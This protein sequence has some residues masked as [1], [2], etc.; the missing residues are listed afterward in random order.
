LRGGAN[1]ARIRLQ[2]QAGWEVNQPEQLKAVLAKYE[3]IQSGTNA[4]LADLIVLGG[5]VGIEM[6][7]KKAGA[8]INVPFAPGRADASQEQTDVQSFKV[9]EPLYDGFRNYLQ[10]DFSTAAESLLV[11]KAQLLGLTAPEMTVLLGGLRM[12]GNN[13]GGSSHGVFTASPETLSND[14]FVNLLDMDTEW[15]PT[16]DKNVFNGV[17]RKS[18]TKKWTAT[19]ADLIFG[20]NSQL[21][22]ISEVYASDDAKGKFMSDFVA[23]WNKVM[24][25]DRFDLKR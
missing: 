19:R 13:C 12:L 9:L 25:A 14:F 21:R 17:D 22:A 10:R 16:D 5:A 15:K 8:D 23:A 2:P 24:N 3:Q 18:G 20:S 4:S 1:G 6:A 11:D 7:A